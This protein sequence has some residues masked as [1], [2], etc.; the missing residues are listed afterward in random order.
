[1]SKQLSFPLRL[2]LC[3]AL[4][5]LPIAAYGQT[6]ARCGQ[7][8]LE[9]IDGYSVLH[10]K[11]TPYEMGYQHGALLKESIRE[12][13]HNVLESKRV[14]SIDVGGVTVN[15]RLVID[16][17][18]IVQSPFVPAWYQEELKGVAAGAELKLADVAAANF[19]PELFH[20]SGFAVMNSATADGTLYHGRIL[21]YSCDWHLQD[22]A[23]LIVAE[24]EGGIPF[25][26]VTFAGFIGSVTGMNA[27][28]VSIGEMGGGGLGHWAGTPMAVLVR[29][30]LQQA[31][32][33][34]QAVEVFRNAKRTCEYYYVIADGKT[35]RALG[36]SASWDK[37]ETIEPGQLHP[38]LP[39]PVKDCV[40]LSAGSRYEELARRA[41]DGVGSF[42]ADSVRKL[43]ERPIAGR[44]NL[45]NAL[46]EPASTK[47][48]ITNAASDG[49][50]AADQ[51]YHAFQL[52]ELLEHKPSVDSPEIQVKR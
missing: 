31:K 32:D 50:P 5:Y 45:H 2:F 23:V 17:L 47:M 11:G 20:C 22:H 15:P 1:M 34:D 14:S 9:T 29:Q 43:L 8:W 37:L 46:F 41:A 35:N 49:K 10:L 12:N 38:L 6:I 28:H 13:L 33:L 44:S 16:T 40:L 24:P 48:W 25:A 39:K 18:A 27:D 3:L 52:T 51:P 26:N 42:D 4:I 36:V 21:D 19:L 7:G 30:V